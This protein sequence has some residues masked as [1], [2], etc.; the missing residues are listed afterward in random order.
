VTDIKFAIVGTGPM[1]ATM[2]STFARAGVR[3]QA[4]VSKSEE[5]ASRF[6]SA[7]DISS[8][9]TN[10]ATVLERSDIDAVYVA[11]APREHATTCIAA[12]EAGKAV[13]CE[14]PIALSEIETQ[15]VLQAARKAQILCMEGL[16]TLLLPSYRRFLELSL[17]EASGSRSNLV[18]GFGYP[19]N[20]ETQGALL[21]PDRGAMLD[22]GVYLIALALKVFGPVDRV[23]AC[24]ELTNAGVDREA[25]LQLR[26]RNGGYS[27]LAAS[28]DNLLSNNATLSC[29]ERSIHLEPPL[30]GSESVAI[31]RK[32]RL[33]AQHVAGDSWFREK[34]IGK[35]RA[36]SHLRRLNQAMNRSTSFQ[37]IPFGADRYLPEVNHF[38]DLLRSGAQQSE[39]VPLNL[40]L[41]IQRIIDG[42]RKDNARQ[43]SVEQGSS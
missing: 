33:N 6:A 4:V 5:R 42:A 3:V 37:H 30:I 1:A 41:G 17:Q 14:K 24:L 25:F 39:V 18:A 2:M 16:W 9:E 13:L 32:P 38:I 12:L 31:Q 20:E 29:S 23:D 26:H 22:R 34:I 8:S 27:Q 21:A 15:G 7:F 36:N 10:L 35:L 11:N 43:P 40:S 19:I 28:F